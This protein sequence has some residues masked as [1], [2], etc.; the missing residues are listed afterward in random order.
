MLGYDLELLYKDHDT[1]YSCRGKKITE[2]QQ[3]R[4][5]DI[6]SFQSISVIVTLLLFIYKTAKWR[7]FPSA[8]LNT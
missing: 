7:Y 3:R 2:K 8:L 1:W 4:A 5:D 6:R